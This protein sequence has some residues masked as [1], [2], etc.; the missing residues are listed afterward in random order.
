MRAWPLMSMAQA[1]QTS[2]RQLESSVTGV[3]F[4]PSLVTGLAAMS[5]SD[6]V[7]FMPG[8]WGSSNSSQ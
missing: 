5:I 3:V 6:E 4:L 7:T 2:S 1:P 8:R